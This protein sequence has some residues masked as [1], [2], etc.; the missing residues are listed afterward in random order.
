MAMLTV[1]NLDEGLKSQLRIRAAEDG[2]SMEEEARRILGAALMRPRE[3]KGIGSRLHQRILEFTGGV[4]L[5]LPSRS[6]PRS[7]P[8]F[9]DDGG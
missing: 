7:A 5:Q 8:D 2:C 4:E 9:G 6:M 3:G 1:R